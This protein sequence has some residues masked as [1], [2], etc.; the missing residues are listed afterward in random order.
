MLLKFGVYGYIWWLLA[1]HCSFCSVLRHMHAV[2]AVHSVQ[3]YLLAVSAS[4]AGAAL[5]FE[6]KRQLL[7][8]GWRFAG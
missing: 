4:A 6:F 1:C 2:H 8:L 3:L 5:R 7:L